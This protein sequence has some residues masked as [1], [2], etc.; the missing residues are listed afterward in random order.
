[1]NLEIISSNKSFGGWH[2]RYRHH[3]S[4]LGCEMNFAIYLPPQALTGQKVPVLYWLSGLTCTDE[5]FMQKAGALRIAAE[6]GIAGVVSLTN[7]CTANN[8]VA[9]IVAS[10]VARDLAEHHGVTPRRAA[11]MLDI[12][13]CVIQGLIPWG[14]QALLL[15]SIF[16]LSPLAVVSMSFYPMAL[17]LAALVAVFVKHQMRQ[18]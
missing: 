2:K 10:K 8:T 14:A 18:R 5:N 1:M 3:A 12:F 6:L 16:A 9:I 13:S 11:S 7:L 4:V 17:A 15:G